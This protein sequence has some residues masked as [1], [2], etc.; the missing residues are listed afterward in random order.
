VVPFEVDLILEPPRLGGE[1]LSLATWTTD[2]VALFLVMASG[3]WTACRW[4]YTIP[5]RDNLLVSLCSGMGAMTKLVK[6]PAKHVDVSK[7]MAEL[8]RTSC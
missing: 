7:E 8:R 1:R 3:T 4:T 6:V 5:H 2:E